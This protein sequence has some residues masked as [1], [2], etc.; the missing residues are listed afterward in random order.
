MSPIDPVRQLELDEL[1]ATVQAAESSPLGE[2]VLMYLREIASLRP[3]SLEEERELLTAIELG[4]EAARHKLTE[5]NLWEVVRIAQS[6]IGRG[7]A[8]LD[9]VQE[10]NLGL[11]RAVSEVPFRPGSF[12]E[13]R[14]ARVVEAIERALS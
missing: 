10:G 4:D 6:F 2:P 7:I 13:R 5:L 14:H 3:L 1:V 8:L 11:M 12:G 9:L